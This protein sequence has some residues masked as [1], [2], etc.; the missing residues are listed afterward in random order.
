MRPITVFLLLGVLGLTFGVRAQEPAWT[1]YEVDAN[2]NVRVNLYLFWSETCPHC[3]GALQFADWLQEQHAWVNVFRYEVTRNPANRELYRRMATS[4][5]KV[6]GPTPAFFYCKQLQIGYLSYEQTGRRIEQSMIRW[7]ES[8]RDYYRKKSSAPASR[9]VVGMTGLGLW[10]YRAV[11]P[12]PPL[13]DLPVEPPVDEEK[14]QIPG[15]GDVN[16]SNLSL[17][18]LTLVLAGCDAFNPCAF[19]VLLLLLSMLVHGRSRARM[20]LVGGIFVFFSGLLYFL[21]MAAWL[22]LFLVIGHLSLITAAAGVVAVFIG[23]LNVKD[24]FWLK[25]G[26]SLSIPDSARPGLFQRISKLINTSSLP[27]LLVGAAALASAANLYELLCTAGFPMVY[28]RVLTLSELPTAGYY[29]YLVLYNLIYVAP[30]ALIVGVFVVTLGARKLTEYEGRVLKLLSGVMMLA[31]GGSLVFRPELLHTLAAETR[32]RGVHGKLNPK[33]ANLAGRGR[34][35]FVS[36]QRPR[37][38]EKSQGVHLFET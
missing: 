11:A 4:L 32:S 13:P 20:T 36:G 33:Q 10:P 22:N 25:Q 28:T 1:W 5:Q 2:R 7:Y 38:G 23:L 16:A 30:M 9:A 19:F 34:R 29:A 12:E 17:P 27:A 14:I 37:Q 31:L 15:W 6:G 35:F 26:P 18:A 3:P 8:L 21:F 24:Y